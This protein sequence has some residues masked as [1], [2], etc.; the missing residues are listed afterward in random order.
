VRLDHVARFIVNANH[1]IMCAAERPRVADCVADYD[2]VSD[3]SRKKTD[4]WM[5]TSGDDGVSWT[6]AAKVTT[7]QTDETTANADLGNQYGDYNGLSG[8][9]GKFF[10]SWTDRRS[11]GVEEIWTAASPVSRP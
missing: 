5:Q 2:T 11:G 4:L 8:Y 6:A 7:A 10:P 1:G 9:A 3:A